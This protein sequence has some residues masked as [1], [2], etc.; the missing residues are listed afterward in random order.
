MQVQASRIAGVV[1]YTKEEGRSSAA[2]ARQTIAGINFTGQT[3][4]MTLHTG[5]IKSFFVVV[6]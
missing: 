3:S 6:R 5:V 1:Y 2:T 4:N